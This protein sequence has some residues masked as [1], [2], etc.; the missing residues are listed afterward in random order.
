MDGPEF[1]DRTPRHSSA[2]TTWRVTRGLAAAAVIAGAAFLAAGY[3]YGDP[4]FAGLFEVSR[5]AGAGTAVPSEPGRPASAQ[6]VRTDTPPA[7]FEEQDEPLG[8]PQKPAAASSSYRFLAM[9][10]DGTPVGYSPCRPLHFV[11]NAALA[12]E[13]AARLVEDAIGTI[14]RATG[15]TFVD[16]GATA[17]APS[18]S[19]IPYQP[20]VYGERWA[21]LLIAWTTPDQAPQLK[22]P[23]IGT[24]GST[25]FS[26]GA[27]PKSFVTGSL[28]LDA[29][30]IAEDLSRKDGAAYATAVILHELGHVM[31]LEH[32]DD[33]VQLMY[34][35]I[36]APDGLAAGD[37]N[38]LY[39]LGK[40]QCR[41]DL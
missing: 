40:A 10:D 15:I 27:G 18:Q 12:P 34:P 14:S 26:F 32:V 4:R 20:A 16:D 30:Q 39:E 19:R 22:G 21:P 37:R 29:P 24:G 5:G 36:G 1:R 2:R 7:G 13:G 6:A 25:H 17:E 31:G 9:N 11:V 8:R 41:K 33:P 35:E 38:G 3:I 23:V 28:E